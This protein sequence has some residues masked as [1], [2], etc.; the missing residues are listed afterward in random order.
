MAL[1]RD[2]CRSCAWATPPETARF[3]VG[4]GNF[5]R[6]DCPAERPSSPGQSWPMSGVAVW[7]C[8]DPG[9]RNMFDPGLSVG[10]T[11]SNRQLMSVFQCACEGGIRYSSKTGTIVIVVNNTKAGLPNV[12]KDGIL[13]FAGRILTDGGNL[14]GANLR[15][16]TFL[17]GGEDVFLF[18]VNQPGK[19]EFR[20]KAELAAAPCLATTEDGKKYPVFP[21]KII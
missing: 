1:L 19:Y 18:E 4:A 7:N 9:R 10:E 5:L 12:W 13:R 16:E 11:L 17:Q 21:L 3:R 6:G 14:K 2:F 8:G 15:L 20:G